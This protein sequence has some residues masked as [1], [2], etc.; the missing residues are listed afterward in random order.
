MTTDLLPNTRALIARSPFQSELTAFASWLIA[1]RYTPLA[2]HR[3]STRVDAALPPS[4]ARQRVAG[5]CG[6]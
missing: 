4:S 2:V 3:H 5:I 6:Q 1:E